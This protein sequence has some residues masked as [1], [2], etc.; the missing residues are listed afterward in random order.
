M[1]PKVM[2]KPPFDLK[3]FLAKANGGRT[4][5]EY[6]AIEHF[7]PRRPGRRHL[8]YQEGN[9]KLTVVSKQGKEAVVAI[10][11]RRRFLWRRMPGGTTI[12]D[13]NRNCNFGVFRHE[14]GEG[15]SGSAP[16][17]TNRPSQNFSWPIFFL[18]TSRLKKT[19]WTNCSIPARR[20]WHECFCCWRTS[21]RKATGFGHPED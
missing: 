20:G 3:V 18:A 11:K 17:R 6:R 14:A 2:P 13:G 9:V 21:G 8:L 16:S 1:E 10:L 4:N 15:G 12:A 5:A 19:W 7:C